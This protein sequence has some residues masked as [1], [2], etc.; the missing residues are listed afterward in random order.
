MTAGILLSLH[1]L[2]YFHRLLEEA[3]DAIRAGDISPLRARVEGL[4]MRR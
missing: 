4:G 2:R 1:N 3:R